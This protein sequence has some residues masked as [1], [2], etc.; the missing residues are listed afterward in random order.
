VGAKFCAECGAPMVQECARCATRLPPQA[1]FCPECA[2]PVGAAPSSVE[3]RFVSPADYTPQHIAEKILGSRGALEGERKHV[4]VLFADLKGSM[5]LLADRDAE[6]ARRVLDGVLERMMEA[7]HHY[8][9]T[10]NQVTAS[11]RCSERPSPTR[12][13]PCGPA[14]PRC[15]CSSAS[16][17]TPRSSIEAWGFR[18]TSGSA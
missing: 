14:S 12:T 4:T 15:A 18:S 13:T 9:G 5:E 6:D 7:V 11:W 3:P 8:E 1:K 17:I 16:G 10:V 2:H